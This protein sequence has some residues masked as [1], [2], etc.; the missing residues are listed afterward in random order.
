MGFQWLLI[1]ASGDP[2]ILDPDNG[3]QLDAYNYSIPLEVTPAVLSSRLLGSAPAPVLDILTT[4]NVTMN[5]HHYGIYTQ[6]FQT[7]SSLTSFFNLLSV[8]SD[9]QG[10]EFVSTIEAFDYPIYGTQVYPYPH[11]HSPLI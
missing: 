9:R 4:Q 5:N 10:V 2:N 1:A 8:N 6:H 11:T 7:T 3:K